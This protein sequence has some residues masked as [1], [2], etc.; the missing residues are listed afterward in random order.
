MSPEPNASTGTDQ[1]VGGAAFRLSAGSGH[2][3]FSTH[4]TVAGFA[5][6]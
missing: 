4:P 2:A 3:F 1:P 6:Y 5:F